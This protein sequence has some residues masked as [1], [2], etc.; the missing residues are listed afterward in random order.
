M[1]NY[2][3]MSTNGRERWPTN[4]EFRNVKI[5]STLSNDKSSPN[6]QD[7]GRLSSFFSD[8]VQIITFIF[9]LLHI[10]PILILKQRRILGFEKL[11]GNNEVLSRQNA[12]RIVGLCLQ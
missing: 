8:H 1:T 10:S 7:Q 9:R 5:S 11:C 4:S 6:T 2:Q 12:T 3:Q